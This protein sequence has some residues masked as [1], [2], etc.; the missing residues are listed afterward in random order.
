VPSNT[1]ASANVNVIE[2]AAVREVTI[3][4]WRI[5]GIDTSDQVLHRENASERLQSRRMLKAAWPKIN[6]L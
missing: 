1:G 3:E 2:I 4:Q 6:V 5:S